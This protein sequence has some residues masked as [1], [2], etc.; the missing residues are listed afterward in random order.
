MF[1]NA[2]DALNYIADH[3]IAMVD[4][5]VAGVAGQWLR[6]IGIFRIPEEVAPPEVLVRAAQLRAGI[7]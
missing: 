2:S 7:H 3:D 1:E 6:R 4:L 5:K